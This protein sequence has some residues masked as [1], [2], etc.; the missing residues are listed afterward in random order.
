MRKTVLISFVLLFLVSVACAKKIEPSVQE[1]RTAPPS[2]VTPAK[3]AAQSDWDKTVIEAKREGTVTIYSIAGVPTRDAVTRAFEQKYGIKVEFIPGRGTELIQK[4]IREQ[5]V[6]LYL[7]DLLHAGLSSQILVAKPAGLLGNLEELLKLPEVTDPKSWVNGK[8][9]FI[10]K[11]RQVFG[12]FWGRT[13]PIVRNTNLTKETDFVDAFD[14]LRPEYRG[15]IVIFDPA[16][17]GPS[18]TWVGYRVS[19]FWTEEKT[20]EFLQGL[21]RQEAVI[22]RDHRFMVNGVAQ[23]K[24]V[25]GLFTLTEEANEFMK[26]GAP[27]AMVKLKETATVDPSTGVI[28]APKTFA[29]RNAAILFLNWLLSREGQTVM[30]KSVGSP[31]G[32]VD[33]S[34]EGVVP[35][36]IMAPGEKTFPITEED[37]LLRDRWMAIAREILAPLIR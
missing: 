13:G 2:A 15:K 8:L 14:F 3:E 35:Y 19:Y 28:S 16:F 27:I 11:D 30:V 25:L 17:P 22:T 29:H 7:A 20:R 10:D 12:F 9:P 32:R 23:G 18:S 37:V 36:E 33:V 31:S 21:V 26:L 4:M 6:G 24:Y 34:T 1:S 5:R